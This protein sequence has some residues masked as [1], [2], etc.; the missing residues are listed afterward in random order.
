MAGAPRDGRAWLTTAAAAAAPAPPRH[1]PAHVR[2][3]GAPR[4][5]AHAEHERIPPLVDIDA[6]TQLV[7]NQAKR[8]LER[9]APPAPPNQRVRAR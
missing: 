4:L 8:A 1:V 6:S 3:H 5:H 2:Q 7:R 9:L